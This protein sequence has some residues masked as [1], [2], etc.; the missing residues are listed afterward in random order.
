MRRLVNVLFLLAG[1]KARSR[2]P[3]N[4]L[5]HLGQTGNTQSN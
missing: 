2:E 3:W 5:S 4:K 1:M